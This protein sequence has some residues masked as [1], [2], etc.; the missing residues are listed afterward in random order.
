MPTARVFRTS[1]FRIAVVYLAL[2]ALTLG[3]LLGFVWWTAAGLVDRQ[4]SSTVEADIRGLAE[5]YREEGLPRLVEVIRGRIGPAGDP[6]NVY[7][8]AGPRYQPL[9]GNLSSWPARRPGPGGWVEVIL[10]RRDEP[11]GAP[12]I[13]LGRTFELAGGYHLFVGRNTIERA[14]LRDLLLRALA[15]AL[16]PVLVLGL[17][18][19]LL[20]SRYS[21]RRVD[22]VRAIGEEIVNGDLTRRLPRD[23]SADELD[24]LAESINEMLDRIETLMGGMQLVTESLAHDLRSPLMRARSSIEMALREEEDAEGYRRT[25]EGT[26]AELEIILRTFESL[27]NIAQAEAGVNRLSLEPLDLSALAGDLVEL[28]QPIGEEAGLAVSADIAPDLTIEGHRQLLGQALANLFDNAVKFTP[29]GGEVRLS[30]ARADDAV[31]LR[32]ADSGP[33]IPETERAR[34]L[35]RFV[36]LD[37]SRG[38]PGSGLG[39]SLVA[40][41][42][43]LHGATLTLG[44]AQPGLA[45]TLRFPPRP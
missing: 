24:R 17:A 7:L 22:A 14:R 5:Q 40:A 13:V 11:D 8:L 33:G 1:T 19:G 35:E 23:G 31:V 25:L 32:L 9:A 30:L 15:W 43:K 12:H 27:I 3:A 4:L 45:V 41:V 29:A 34:V 42:A 36:R 18:G 39:L 37:A 2:L 6:R 28:Y 21:L 26:A 16:A 10:E 38:T 20:V 44:D